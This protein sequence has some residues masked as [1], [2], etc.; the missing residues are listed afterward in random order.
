MIALPRT[1]G[2]TSSNAELLDHI[3]DEIL[4]DTIPQVLHRS[5][6]DWPDA[7][8]SLLSICIPGNRTKAYEALLDLVS[9]PCKESFYTQY[10]DLYAKIIPDLVKLLGERSIDISSFPS[11]KFFGYIIGRYLEEILGSK[12][13]SPYLTIPTLTWGHEACSQANDFLRSKETK[14]TISPIDQESESCMITGLRM[15]K[16]S[17]LLEYKIPWGHEPPWMDLTKKH[18]AIAGQDW[19]VRLSDTQKVL[20]S[21]GT[22]EEISRIMGERYRDVG[23]ALE[24]SQAFV[25]IKAEDEPMDGIQ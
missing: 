25:I 5:R 23:K 7:V 22:E 19:S 9:D 6:Y 13:R 14:R 1:E 18:E 2:Q 16:R 17:S 3:L 21:I 11:R 8:S 10:V 20:E 24:G 15:D 12:E 4:A